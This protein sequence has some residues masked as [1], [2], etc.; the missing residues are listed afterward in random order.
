MKGQ[1]HLRVSTPLPAQRKVAKPKGHSARNNCLNHSN[2]FPEG[3]G[4]G[5]KLSIIFLKPFNNNKSWQGT[6]KILLCFIK[7]FFFL[8]II[9]DKAYFFIDYLGYEYKYIF[10]KTQEAKEEQVIR[11]YNNKATLDFTWLTTGLNIFCKK[12]WLHYFKWIDH[13]GLN[14]AAF[15]FFLHK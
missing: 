10:L 7:F 2:S 11:Q 3:W 14:S 9:E 15:G 13:C 12:K 4:G 8:T 5:W 1:K 6:F